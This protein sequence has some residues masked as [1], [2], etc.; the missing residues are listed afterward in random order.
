MTTARRTQLLALGFAMAGVV[1]MLLLVTLAARTGP[2]GLVQ[3]HAYDGIFHP[4]TPKV[5][6][7]PNPARGPDPS[8]LR[9]FRHAR[10][11][12]PLLPIIGAVIKYAVLAYLLVLLWRALRWLGGV[13]R[14]RRRHEAPPLR[15]TFDV[16][17]DPQALLAEMRRDAVRQYELLLGGT[18]RN[19]IVACWD[20]FE[21]QAERVG[22]AR[23]PWE[24]SSEFTMH[25]LEAVSAD[26]RQVRVLE[27]L[28]R[29]AR[30]S[31]HDITEP[32][33]ATALES[34][35]AIHES[36]GATAGSR[37]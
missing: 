32:M 31:D 17:D 13:L 8:T 6:T 15:A 18:P 16:L 20:R 33:R 9:Q 12:S 5:T 30:F 3:G 2:T 25:L 10:S 1:L 7:P 36:I 37:R 35:Q 27:L 26:A 24:T 21:E 4:P 19:G 22:A 23:R 29:E 14:A 34:L 11:A 28:Y